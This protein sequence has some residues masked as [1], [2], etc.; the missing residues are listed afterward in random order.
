MCSMESILTKCGDSWYGKNRARM[1]ATLN[2]FILRD[3]RSVCEVKRGLPEAPH[4]PLQYFAG[5]RVHQPGA[6]KSQ[7]RVYVLI[8]VR[9]ERRC[10]ECAIER[11]GCVGEQGVFEIDGAGRHIRANMDGECGGEGTQLGECGGGEGVYRV[12]VVQVGISAGEQIGLGVP[13]F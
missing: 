3:V 7:E 5:W 10:L 4:E 8:E 9:I 11:A 1:A 2:S 13:L 6:D 12:E